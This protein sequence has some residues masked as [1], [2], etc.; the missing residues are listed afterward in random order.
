MNSKPTGAPTSPRA[1]SLIAR[2]RHSLSQPDCALVLEL[3][4]G[5]L[6]LAWLA[7]VTME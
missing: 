6:L 3:A 5:A 7:H 2:V 4:S 1:A